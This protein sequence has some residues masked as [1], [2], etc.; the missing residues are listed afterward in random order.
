M[1]PPADLLT[2]RINNKKIL[3]KPADPPCLGEALRRVT[4][5]NNDDFLEKDMIRSQCKA[6][7]IISEIIGNSQL[8]LT[9]K[10]EKPAVGCLVELSNKISRDY[11][12][13]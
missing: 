11:R 5:I 1:L 3:T 4:F 12:S 8:I 6:R 2:Q 7:I 10:G 9:L 13:H